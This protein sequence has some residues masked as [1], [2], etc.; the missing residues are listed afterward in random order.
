[1]SD[2]VEAVD[3]SE[4]RRGDRLIAVYIGVLAVALSIC[5]MG[6]GNATKHAMARNIEAANTWTFFS[7]P[8]H[9][10]PT[11]ATSDG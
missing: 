4:K 3:P 10:A 2:L 5:S 1:M 11:V 9:S 7:S 8:E 6:A